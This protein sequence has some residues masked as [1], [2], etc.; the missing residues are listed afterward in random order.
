MTNA[1]IITV[2]CAA[3]GVM[4]K[5]DTYQG[6]KRAGYQVQKGSRALFSTKIWKPRNKSRRD[7]EREEAGEEV[8]DKGRFIMVKAS[9]FGLS[10]V[11]P[12]KAA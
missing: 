11:A 8:E 6:W 10:Q 1:E 5:V 4:E 12:I 9:F 3:A 7:I 2:A